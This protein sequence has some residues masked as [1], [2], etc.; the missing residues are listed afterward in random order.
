MIP[1]YLHS[2]SAFSIPSQSG[3]LGL[4]SVEVY[5]QE[6]ALRLRIPSRS[7]WR[8]T[9]SAT[10]NEVTGWTKD[11]GEDEGRLSKTKCQGHSHPKLSVAQGAGSK[12]SADK[13]PPTARR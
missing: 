7:D 3:L 12:L 4:V 8:V 9:P 6:N 1:L 10:L 11:D 2:S 13:I 5:R